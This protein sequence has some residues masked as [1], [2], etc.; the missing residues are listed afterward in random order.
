MVKGFHIKTLLFLMVVGFAGPTLTERGPAGAAPSV[1]GGVTNSYSAES[2]VLTGM[3]VGFKPGNQATVVPLSSKEA[4]NLVGVVVPVNDAPIVLT[5]PQTGDTHQVLVAV[6]G[7]H[8]VLVSDQSGQVK[9][10]DY[11]TVSSADGIAMKATPDDRLAIGR[12]ADSF[13]GQANSIGSISLKNTLGQTTK[14]S[15][16]R[17]RF[18]IQLS[19]NPLQKGKYSGL[20]GFLSRVAN[21]VTN[22][23]VSPL[24][25]YVSTLVLGITLFVCALLLYGGTR[26]SII[27]IGRNP[28]A[29]KAIGRGLASTM[30]V[31]LLLLIAGMLTAYLI[32]SL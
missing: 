23:S 5:T 26:S 19:A 2:S 17:V 29:K 27:A 14:V 1:S 22:K 3:L 12:A 10:G 30:A 25:V 21:T 4:G 11:L 32:I 20:P 6:S 13:D 8:E 28:L 7:R 24:R 15:V 18:D 9:T 16:G 31:G